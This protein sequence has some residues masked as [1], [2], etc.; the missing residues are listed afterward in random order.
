[1]VRMNSLEEVKRAISAL[2]PEGRTE[3]IK[4]LP[5]LLPE[6]EGD[7]AW[8]RII[9]DPT[10]NPALS[11]FV[12]AVDAEYQRDPE[13]FPEIKENDFDRNA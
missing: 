12:D 11:A 7:L 13:S 4:E 9:D 10:R 8:R 5:T 6:L 2:S 3:L 1:M